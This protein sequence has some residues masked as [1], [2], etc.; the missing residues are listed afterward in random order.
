VAPVEERDGGKLIHRWKTKVGKGMFMFNAEREIGLTFFSKC[1]W[2]LMTITTLWTNLFP[3][4]LIHK[5]ISP[6][7]SVLSQNS[8]KPT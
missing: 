8:S 4:S 5:C 6:F 7:N 2:C 1:F 3:Q